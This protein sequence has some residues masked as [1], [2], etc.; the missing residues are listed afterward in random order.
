MQFFS[1]LFFYDFF[2]GQTFWIQV[3]LILLDFTVTDAVVLSDFVDIVDVKA[4]AHALHGTEVFYVQLV[5]F[6]ICLINQYSLVYFLLFD[7]FTP[8]LC[9]NMFSKKLSI[10]T[11]LR[12][13]LTIYRPFLIR[14]HQPR[15][16]RIHVQLPKLLII[17]H[18][19]WLL[20]QL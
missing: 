14:Y 10:D 20:I 1:P 8:L 11:I 17:T 2:F 16:P 13:Q 4:F 15:I 19:R 6:P 5:F 12:L 7:N 3:G 9:L 18:L